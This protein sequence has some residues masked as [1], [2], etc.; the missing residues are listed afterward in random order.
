MNGFI[1]TLTGIF[2]F[3]FFATSSTPAQK[4][5]SEELVAKHLDS[6]GTAEV[7]TAVK[8][9]IIV[10][11]AVVTFVSQKNLNAVGRVV[12]ASAGE[13]NFF[14]LSLNALDY[15]REQFVFDGSRSKIAPVLDGQRSYLGSFVG[16]SE[17]VIRGSLLGGTLASSWVLKDLVNKKAKLSFE[18]TKKIDG[19]EYYALGYSSKG[20]SDFAITL[21]F[22][23]NTFRHARTEYKRTASAG[24]GTRPEQSSGFQ[25]TRLKVT[26]VFSDFRV[27][28]GLTLP[29]TYK[30]TYSEIGQRGTREVEWA[31]T[32]NE[33]AFN[34][35]MDEK[36]FEVQAK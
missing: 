16:S 18:G 11:D 27:E 24:I 6:I 13:K 31:Y 5:T 21:Y 28:N 1:R 4:M 10:G 33:F 20:G 26:E 36:T 14:G 3:A 35:P 29:H 30:L 23:K 9:Q 2:V 34:Q 25:E 22:E 8:S 7:R 17:I 15:P 32:L 12:M 19:E